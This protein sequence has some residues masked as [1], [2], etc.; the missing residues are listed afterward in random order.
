MAAVPLLR[1]RAC[2]L[3]SSLAARADIHTAARSAGGRR[4]VA[5]PTVPRHACRPSSATAAKTTGRALRDRR[6]SHARGGGARGTASA[7]PARSDVE[8][9]CDL[10]L[11]D[12]AGAGDR[13]GRA[14]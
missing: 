11:G 5:G 9:P 3:S 14:V 4:A 2:V 8:P 7:W 10:V 13:V 6:G 1:A 12:G